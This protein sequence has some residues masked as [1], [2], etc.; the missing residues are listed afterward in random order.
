MLWFREFGTLEFI[1]IFLFLIA[2]V[3]YVVRIRA[4]ARILGL[5]PTFAWWVKIGG[6]PLILGLLIV[7]LLGPVFGSA[8]R[9][10]KSIGKD[11][12]FCVDLSKSMDAFDVQPSRLEK[13]K[14]EMKRIVD[15]FNSDRVGLIIFSSEAFMQC[16][17]T[18][19][20]NALHLLI[21]TMNTSLVP[22]AG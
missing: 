11:I 22:N 5:S 9:E 8:R 17:L 2:S 20:Q 7:A 16:P 1:W 4:I 21:E 3:S 6:R 14:F 13:A 10:V 18:F 19:D 15:A 12:L